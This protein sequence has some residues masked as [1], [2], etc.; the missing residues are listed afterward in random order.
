MEVRSAAPNG[1]GGVLMPGDP[2]QSQWSVK[3]PGRLR[4]ARGAFLFRLSSST[5]SRSVILGCEQF[6]LLDGDF[7]QARETL[8]LAQSFADEEGI[9]IFQI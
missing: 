1:L 9:E 6:H 2:G 7:V 3:I 8:G 4:R 5:K